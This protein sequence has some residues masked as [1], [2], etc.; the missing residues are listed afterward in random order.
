MDAAKIISF[1]RD[2]DLLEMPAAPWP[3]QDAGILDVSTPGDLES[4]LPGPGGVTS[5]RVP[6]FVL[7]LGCF[8][9]SDIARTMI[10]RIAPGRAPDP[11]QID[12]MSRASTALARVILDWQGRVLGDTF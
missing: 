4:A 11:G 3:R 7:H 1:Y 5:R 10:E 6:F 12:R 8:R 9:Q 2:V